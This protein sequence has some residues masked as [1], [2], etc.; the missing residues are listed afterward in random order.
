MLQFPCLRTL[1]LFSRRRLSISTPQRLSLVTTGKRSL[2]I[3]IS[4]PKRC[5]Q[6]LRFWNLFPTM[7]GTGEL[8][9]KL[10]DHTSWS[11]HGPR[12]REL[13]KAAKRLFDT[14]TQ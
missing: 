14:V 8:T 1:F 12:S 4:T 11:G 7:S 5:W 10:I 3:N 2:R 6:F 13:T 9:F